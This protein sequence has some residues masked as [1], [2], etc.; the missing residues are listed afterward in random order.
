MTIQL[1]N[2]TIETADAVS[3][4]QLLTDAGIALRGIAVAVN[5]RVVPKTEWETTQLND[6]DNVVVITATFGG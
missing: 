4:A 6:N 2:Q 3:V 5:K 1:N